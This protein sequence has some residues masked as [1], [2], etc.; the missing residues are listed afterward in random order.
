MERRKTVR[1]SVL[2]RE[3]EGSFSADFKLDAE[4]K[5]ATPPFLARIIIW[6]QTREMTS[7]LEIN[8]TTPVVS[9]LETLGFSH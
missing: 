5:V 7:R 3:G 9:L 2:K 6:G 1:L 4:G 8:E